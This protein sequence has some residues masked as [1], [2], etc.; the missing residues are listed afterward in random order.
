MK[1]HLKYLL[2]LV[3]LISQFSFS[4]EEEK[5]HPLLTDRFVFV[6]GAFFPSKTL[7]FSVN[8]ESIDYDFDLGAAFDLDNYQSTLNLGFQWRFA[9][10]WKLIANY[11]DIS[12]VYK[13]SLDEPVEWEDYIFD[14]EIEFGA[15]VGVLRSLV[16][17]SFSQGLKHEFGAGIGFHIMIISLYLEGQASLIGEDDGIDTDFQ[18]VSTNATA[19]LP[20]IGIWYYWTPNSRWALTADVDWLYIAFGNYKG[21]L[22]DITGGVQYQIV[23]FFGVG[24]NY[25]YFAVDLEVDQ[26]DDSGNWQGGAKVTYNGPMVMVNFNF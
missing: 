3:V 6:G 10:K 1:N 4:Q 5:K 12:N 25:R 8:G 13:A 15:K 19:P 16:G 7:E 22:W 17:R 2:V 14:A 18:S 9:K 21:G 26:G 11:Y 23:K 24:V 20:D